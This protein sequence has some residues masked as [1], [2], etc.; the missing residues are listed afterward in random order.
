MFKEPRVIP[1]TLKN[2]EVVFVIQL[3]HGGFFGQEWKGNTREYPFWKTKEDAEQKL[4]ILLAEFDRA[5]TGG[6]IQ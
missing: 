4:I 6:V 2:G 5:A 1:L 3:Q